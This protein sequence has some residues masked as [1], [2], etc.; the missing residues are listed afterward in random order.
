MEFVDFEGIV[1]RGVF[2]AVAGAGATFALVEVAEL[3]AAY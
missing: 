3:R 2:G 1:G